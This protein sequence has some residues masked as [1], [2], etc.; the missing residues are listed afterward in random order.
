M[1]LP[2]F[3]ISVWG[4]GIKNM[5]IHPFSSKNKLLYGDLLSK[6]E[7]HYSQALLILEVAA[8]SILEDYCYNLYSGCINYC[9][10]ECI[11]R[12][13]KKTA[14]GQVAM[15]VACLGFTLQQPNK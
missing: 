14:V 1:G 13:G 4:P 2:L 10:L 7:A 9:Q 15:Q 11:P 12:A 3:I 8:N 6:K 5:L